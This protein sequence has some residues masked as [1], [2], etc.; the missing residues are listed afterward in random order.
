[1]H[2]VQEKLLEQI[3][4]DPSIGKLTLREIGKRIG[5]PA[6]Q[7]VKH[8]L[9]QLERFGLISVDRK[10]GLIQRIKGGKIHESST[11]I[12]IPIL[13]YANCGE[14][15][16]VAEERPEGYLRVSSRLL[17]KTKKIF[18][19]QAVGNSLNRA[20][21][22][23]EKRNLEEGDF[24]IVDYESKNPKNDDYILSVIGGL[25]NL[26]KFKLDKENEQIILSSEST[27]NYSPIFIHQDDDYQIG[28][29]IISVLKSN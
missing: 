3:D 13:G 8:H 24:A 12:S 9:T 28:G 22:G 29:K 15:A 2:L 5:D 27:Q 11:L 1:M 7:K 18:A 4:K 14:A 20:K 10:S 16:V 25:A 23:K 26:K 19:L 6:P 21:I 17:P